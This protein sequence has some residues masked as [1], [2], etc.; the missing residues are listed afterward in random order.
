RSGITPHGHFIAI[1]EKL[2]ISIE[3]DR[4]GDSRK[5]L[6][7]DADRRRVDR[8]RAA[9]AEGIRMGIAEIVS[10]LPFLSGA[11]IR[12]IEPA[13]N[14]GWTPN[15]VTTARTLTI[16]RRNEHRRAAGTVRPDV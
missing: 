13:G 15:R 10:Q 2:R 6:S 16:A 3:S 14:P 4:L 7:D 11:A 1:G 8:Q 5:N 9:L 12:G